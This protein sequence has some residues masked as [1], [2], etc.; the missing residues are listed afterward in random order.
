MSGEGRLRAGHRCGRPGGRGSGSELLVADSYLLRYG[1]DFRYWRKQVFR[2][3]LRWRYEGVVHEYPT[4]LDSCTEERLEGN[5]HVQSRRFGARSRSTDTYQRDARLLLEVLVRDP[6]DARA[7]FYLAQS[8]FDAGEYRRALWLYTRRSEMG[9]WGEEVFHSLLRRAECLERVGQQ[10]G[11]VLSAYLASWDARTTRA[12][13]LHAIARHYRIAEQY[14]LGY[15]FARRACEI[16]Y[17]EQDLLFVAAEV[18]RWRARDE[19][20]VCA[21]HT[22]RQVESLELCV[23]L[24]DEDLLPEDERSRVIANRDA[25][26]SAIADRTALHQDAGGAA[27]GVV[28]INL[29]RRGDRWES[30]ERAA[31]TAAGPGF[32][33]RIRRSTA[34]DG[35]QLELTDEIERR[36]AGNNFGLRRGIV[37]CALSHL[38]VW[39]S[40]ANGDDQAC[41]ILEDDARL[42]DDFERRLRGVSSDLHQRHPDFDLALLGYSSWEAE[43]LQVA[44]ATPPASGV[45]PM[46]WERYLG[47]SYAYLLSQRGAQRLLSLVERDG[48]RNAIDWFVMHHR[49]ELA[50]FECD[51]PIVLSPSMAH[52]VKVDSDIQRDFEPVRAA[53]PGKPRR[54][55]GL[56]PRL[57]SIAPSMVGGPIALEVD[58]PWPSCAATVAGDDRGLRMVVR[59]ADGDGNAPAALDY[60]VWLDDD[61]QVC[62]IQPMTDETGWTGSPAGYDDW[63]LVRAPRGWFA[64][65][66]CR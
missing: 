22:D 15:L 51:P 19:A 57:S 45:R 47:G 62:D 8:Y 3:G 64:S 35:R 36:F 12:E 46:R 41:L 63:R 16:P 21:F 52:G 58:P 2:L 44:G 27:P 37:A 28:V 60:L 13:P 24:L 50:A 29:E 1:T 33:G 7:A 48:V 18:Y 65:A 14:E 61:V 5:Y 17:P 56:V 25:C 32:V 59:T 9:G 10:W 66:L 38:S 11:E 55:A 4:C 53:V 42:S 6:D 30:F 39:E 34:V 20:A 43:T 23:A 40:I 49:E 31:E 54:V 26:V